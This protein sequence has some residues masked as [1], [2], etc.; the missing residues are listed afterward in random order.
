V[1]RTPIT[2]EAGSP[3]YFQ[4]NVSIPS[5]PCGRQ[6]LYFLPDRILVFDSG[7][8]GAVLF[9]QLTVGSAEQ[10]FI[11]SESVPSDA[12]VVDKTWTYV[13]KKGGPDRRFSNNRE[14]PVALYESLLLTSN[15]GLQEMFHTSK[16]GIGSSLNSAVAGM[17]SAIAQ[18][19]QSTSGTIRS[20]TA[21]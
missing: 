19:E 17:A 8:V 15:S 18:R 7:G 13:N 21:N 14:L 9:E 2:S 11:E 4:C 20:N 1:K 16:T 6:T 5:L 12:R 3:P 10:R